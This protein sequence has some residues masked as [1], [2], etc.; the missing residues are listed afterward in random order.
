MSDNGHVYVYTAQFAR[1][2]AHRHQTFYAT[3]KFYFIFR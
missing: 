2:L 3:K 1:M